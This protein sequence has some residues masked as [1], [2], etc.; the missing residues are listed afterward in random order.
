MKKKR[1]GFMLAISLGV[2]LL[3]MLSVEGMSETS[4]FERISVE[5]RLPETKS[6]IKV[7]NQKKV[8]VKA[9]PKL[10]AAPKK[11]TVLPTQGKKLKK[12]QLTFSGQ[13]ISLVNSQG[14]TS[15]PSGNKAGYWRGNGKVNDQKTTHIIGHNPGA[16]SGIFRLKKGS[17]IQVTDS[18]G[19][20][21]NYKVYSILTVNDYGYGKNGKD[22]WSTIFNQKGEAISL[23]ACINED[24]NLIVL[25]K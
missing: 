3:L 4:D 18:N 7:V 25:A 24:W 9:K 14:K 19:K 21:R 12:N 23:Q 20:S 10:V 16:F 5:K 22:Y 17:V 1:F 11:K 13:T 2:S 15:A 8:T 6:K